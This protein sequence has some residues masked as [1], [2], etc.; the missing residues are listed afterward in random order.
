M[1]QGKIRSGFDCDPL[2]FITSLMTNWTG[3]STTQTIRKLNRAKTSKVVNLCGD[4]ETKEGQKQR[5]A[6]I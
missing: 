2:F 3:F 4:I 6:D 5:F 1:I